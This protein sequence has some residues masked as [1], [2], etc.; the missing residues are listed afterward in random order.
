MTIVMATFCIFTCL[1]SQVSMV[2]VMYEIDCLSLVG[3]V[4]GI[5][6][7]FVLVMVKWRTDDNDSP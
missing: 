6:N 5:Y 1:K 4:A 7:F 2:D 3:V